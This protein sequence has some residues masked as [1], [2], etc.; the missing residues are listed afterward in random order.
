MAT[1]IEQTGPKPAVDDSKDLSREVILYDPCAAW[2][3]YEGL[4]DRIFNSDIVG[5]DIRLPRE[6]LREYQELIN[7]R[8]RDTQAE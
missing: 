4:V 8:I 1:L 6:D 2:A 7:G 5:G 3:L